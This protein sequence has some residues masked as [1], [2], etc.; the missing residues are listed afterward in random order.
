MAAADVAL[1]APGGEADARPILGDLAREAVHLSVDGAALP[2]RVDE[3]SFEEGAARVRVSFAIAESRSPVRRLTI[4]SDVPKRVARGHRQLMVVS[5]DDRVLAERLLDA[6]SGPV[7]ID[8]EAASPSAA[9]AAWRFLDLGVHHILSGFDHL[10]FLAGLLLAART[11][12]ELAAELTA[13]TAAHSVSLAL[14]VMAGVRAPASIVEP[15]IAAS[16]AW[17]GLE[18]LRQGRHRRHWLVVFAFGLIHGF[19][20]AGALIELGFGSSAIEMALALLSFNTGVEAGQLAA[21]AAM[22]PLVWMLRSRPVWQAR[23]LPL[24]SAM[25]VMAGAYWLIERLA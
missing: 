6:K 14:V 15:V 8:F 25:I 5:A 2:A 13:F 4:A 18:I 3:V 19:G 7:A 24:C 1:I 11:V 17:V 23:L 16:I 12:R 20:F 22:L 9:R 10:V 21:A